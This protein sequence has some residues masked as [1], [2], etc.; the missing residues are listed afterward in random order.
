MLSQ[1]AWGTDVRPVDF[2]SNV[3]FKLGWREHLGCARKFRK[4]TMFTA[5]LE[6]DRF[7]VYNKKDTLENSRAHMNE[8]LAL[9]R[10]VRGDGYRVRIFVDG[11]LL[12][13]DKEVE[14]STLRTWMDAYKKRT[15]TP[16]TL[17]AAS[18]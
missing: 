16:W 11:E 2:I 1:P 17:R 18:T 12:D 8:L 10:D 15:W 6:M 3:V 13:L 14:D 7:F 5:H 9:A 4:N